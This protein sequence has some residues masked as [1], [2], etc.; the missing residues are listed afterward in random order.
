MK[1]IIDT[2]GADNSPHAMIDGAIL[3][4]EEN[5]EIS[6][7]IVGDEEI[8]KEKTAK[9]K[10]RV[11][12]IHTTAAIDCHQAPA[13]AV[14][15]GE[16]SSVVLG[17]S[18]L[19]KNEE[20]SAFV[21]AGSTGA[22][23]TGAILKVGRIP[24]VLRPALC[25]FLPTKTGNQTMLIDCGA[26]MD[27]KP[28]NLLQFA[29]MATEYLKASGRENPKIA[30][31]SVGAEDEKG[32][33]LVHE[34]FKLLKQK[35]AEGKINFVGNIEAR[36]VLNGE[37]DAVVCDG[38]AGNV[39]L[40][41]AEGAMAFAFSKIKDMFYTNLSTKLGW[42]LCKKEVNKM[43]AAIGEEA[44]GGTI[45]LGILKPV[46]K[47]HGNSNAVAFKNAILFAAEASR[48][49]LKDKISAALSAQ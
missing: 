3:A 5:A 26:N 39:L 46:V 36:D 15:S 32:N 24:G 2:L 11:E 33:E 29:I 1:I 14:R 25:P 20:Y 12:I 19:R 9:F 35:T 23:L 45:F 37:I 38:F 41:T 48:L 31:L 30:L 17:L 13:M 27:S 40:K 42:Q 49:D 4:L 44:A 10:D 34:A 21:S 7:V 8:I 28:E 22:V 18:A 47:A 43:K 16:N 6:V